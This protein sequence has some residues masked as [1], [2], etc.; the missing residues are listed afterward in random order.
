MI[1]KTIEITIFSLLVSS[2][3]LFFTSCTIDITKQTNSKVMSSEAT[4]IKP[5]NSSNLK[6]KMYPIKIPVLMYHYIRDENTNN[7]LVVS[8]KNFEAQMN[9]L[10][11]NGYKTLSLDEL[12]SILK[13]KQN[14]YEKCVLITFDDGYTDNYTNAYPI[15]KKHKQTATIFTIS[16]VL[17]I[18]PSYFMT[19]KN[20][21]ELQANR[22][23][24]ENHTEKHEK[25][26]TL[27]YNDQ[28]KT[29]SKAQSDLQN[30]LEKPIKY[31][32]Y[33]YGSYN[34]DSI[35]ALKST[36]SLMAFTTKKGYV[37]EDSDLFQL[38]RFMIFNTTTLTEFQDIVEQ[39]CY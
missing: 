13:S 10:K 14:P 25:L 29:L 27:S 1:S 8:T 5:F 15:L 24:I 12:H 16:G 4:N 17:D 36:G 32:A 7:E 20:I 31:F 3:L 21:I 22:I 23:A 33:P 28:L 39:R 38:S 6:V 35:K 30:I 11:S 37:T 2:I 9:Y 34:S 26:A 19:T 18:N